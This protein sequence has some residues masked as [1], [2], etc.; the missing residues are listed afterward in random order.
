MNNS[1]FF[2]KT[3]QF[4]IPFFTILGFL[5]TSFKFPEWGLIIAMVAQPFWFY[6]TWKAYKTAG[7]IGMLVTTIIMTFVIGFGI[8]NYWFIA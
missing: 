6:S 2:N 3:T 1:K 5:L 8:I 4:A 7:Q